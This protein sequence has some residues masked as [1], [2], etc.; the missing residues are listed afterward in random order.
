[1]NLVQI[2]LTDSGHSLNH[3][4]KK[5]NLIYE[6]IRKEF[7]EIKDGVGVKIENRFNQLVRRATTR[8]DT[9]L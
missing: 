5:L 6:K 1:M 4:F 3:A 7:G 8:R 2:S 9:Y